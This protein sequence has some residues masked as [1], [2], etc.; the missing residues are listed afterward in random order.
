[1]TKDQEKAQAEEKEN[2][3][4]QSMRSVDTTFQSLV[5]TEELT[6]TKNCI[7]PTCKVKIPA[8]SEFQY[9]ETCRVFAARNAIAILLDPCAPIQTE[10]AT[11]IRYALW[12]NLTA[13]E[14]LRHAKITEEHYLEIQKVIK[15]RNLQFSKDR[16]FRTLN[17]QIEEA[18]DSY[19]SHSV[20][21]KLTRRREKKN[22]TKNQ[23]VQKLLGCDAK[24]AK[25]IMGENFD[26]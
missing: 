20:H 5:E 22:L 16:P 8:N 13:E 1:M 15:S 10:R 6:A 21:A 24:T 17:E 7:Y 9:C 19:E 3:E 25:K 18:R 26:L 12:C 11:D 14:I 23:K 2:R 4:L